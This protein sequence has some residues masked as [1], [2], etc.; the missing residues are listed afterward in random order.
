ML[1][2]VT[3]RFRPDVQAEHDALASDFGDHMR[4]PLLHIHLV[5][6][7]LDDAGRHVGLTLIMEAKDRAQLDHFLAMSPYNRAGLYRSLDV[8]VLQIEAGGLK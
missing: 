6:G 2:M 7:L 8:D 3:A 5:G 1:Y 4:Q